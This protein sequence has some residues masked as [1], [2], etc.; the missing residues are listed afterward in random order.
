MVSQ[1]S[2]LYKSTIQLKMRLPEGQLGFAHQLLHCQVCERKSGRE[3]PVLTR[4]K[5]VC[6]HFKSF[7][8]LQGKPC[9]WFY[10]VD[11][12]YVHVYVD[13]IHWVRGI[14][15]CISQSHAT[16]VRAYAGAAREDPI[17]WGLQAALLPALGTGAFETWADASTG[18]RVVTWRL[19]K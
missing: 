5:H 7:E 18:S 14:Q 13:T 9:T 17:P 19:R 4:V 3:G 16:R 11:P 12:L 15:V 10:F 6:M 8:R 2:K 1:I